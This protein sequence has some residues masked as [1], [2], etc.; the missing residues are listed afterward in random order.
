MSQ[1][2]EIAGKITNC[3][4]NCTECLREEETRNN[5]TEN[6][7]NNADLRLKSGEKGEN[8]GKH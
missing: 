7:I 3:T 8:Y 4:D 6:L 5:G 2:C 1:Y